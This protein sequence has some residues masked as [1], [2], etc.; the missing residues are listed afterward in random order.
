MSVVQKLGK[1][2]TESKSKSQADKNYFFLNHLEESRE[3]FFS[4]YIK[5]FFKAFLKRWNLGATKKVKNLKITDQRKLLKLKSINISII[6]YTKNLLRP[7]YLQS[8]LI[9]LF[10]ILPTIPQEILLC[11]SSEHIKPDTFSHPCCYNHN[12]N[13]LPVC[14]IRGSSLVFLILSLTPIY[15][16]LWLLFSIVTRVIFKTQDTTCTTVLKKFSSS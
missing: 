12:P 1:C 15:S 9:P 10:C 6:Y 4:C 7:S 13:H 5:A 3:N 16:H 14:V 2:F 8:S 11:S